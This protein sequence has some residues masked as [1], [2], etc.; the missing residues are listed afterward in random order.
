MTK[1]ISD[2]II[3]IAHI[4]S[5]QTHKYTALVDHSAY[6]DTLS[7][8]KS[9][10]IHNFSTENKQESIPFRNKKYM[11][12]CQRN[13]H[14]LKSI[15]FKAELG[16]FILTSV[17]KDKLTF[18]ITISNKSVLHLFSL[19]SPSKI[20]LVSELAR[21]SKSFLQFIWCCIILMEIKLLS[22][23]H[24]HP[25]YKFSFRIYIWNGFW[26]E[27]TGCETY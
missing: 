22:R 11:L 1:R 20:T 7:Q 16:E 12:H 19:S 27:R 10:V 25:H 21:L 5:Y 15:D 24:Q 8:Q 14:F 3:C 17:F 23:S 26:K 2:I 6:M 9:R 4:S 13:D 18:N